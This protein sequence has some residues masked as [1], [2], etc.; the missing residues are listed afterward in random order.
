LHP[1]IRIG[2]IGAKPDPERMLELA[3]ALIAGKLDIPIDRMIP[4]AEAS[5]GQAAAEKG[6][7]G[8][9]LLLA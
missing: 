3:H 5:A 8:K 7:I 9:V 1:T 2:M 6:G 4:L